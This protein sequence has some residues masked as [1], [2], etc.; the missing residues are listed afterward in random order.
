[1]PEITDSHRDALQQSLGRAHLHVS[2]ARQCYHS[3]LHRTEKSSHTQARVAGEQFAAAIDRASAALLPFEPIE[4]DLDRLIGNSRDLLSGI[5]E[6]REAAKTAVATWASSGV[7]NNRL[8]EAVGVEAELGWAH[9]QA[10][11]IYRFAVK[12]AFLS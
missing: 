11:E 7:C 1:M 8:A 6:A 9:R 10:E 12:A 2:L 3:F 4:A 5:A